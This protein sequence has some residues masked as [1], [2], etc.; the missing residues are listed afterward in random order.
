[1]L[2][3]RDGGGG[4]NATEKWGIT[5]YFCNHSA[6]A[7]EFDGKK[8]TLLSVL[9]F[10]V[11]KRYI[12]R[13]MYIIHPLQFSNDSYLYLPYALSIYLNLLLTHQDYFKKYDTDS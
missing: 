9:I 6:N 1:M 12:Q 3:R 13:L 11:Q 7:L 4:Y 2:Q 10:L 8:H 5:F